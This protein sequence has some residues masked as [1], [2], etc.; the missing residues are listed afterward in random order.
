[1]LGR[2]TCLGGVSESTTATAVGL[3]RPR[4]AGRIGAVHGGRSPHAPMWH[5]AAVLDYAF[6]GGIVSG[7]AI[8]A[9]WTGLWLVLALAGRCASRV[10]GE[11]LPFLPAAWLGMGLFLIYVLAAHLFLPATA[12][13]WWPFA[14]AAAVELGLSRRS[15]WRGVTGA[16]ATLRPPRTQALA[17]VVVMTVLWLA[18]SAIGPIINYD[19]GLYHLQA[20]QWAHDYPAVP[21]LANL[22]HRFGFTSAWF[23]YVS[24]LGVGP[25]HG[26]TSHIA[27]GSVLGL[28]M[29][30]QWNCLARL[31]FDRVPRP[32]LILGT[33]LLPVSFHQV[34]LGL[35]ASPSYDQ[36]AYSFVVGSSLYALRA[37]SGTHGLLPVAL[38]TAGAAA[39]IRP[40]FAPFATVLIA[41]LLLS[42]VRHGL[43]RGRVALLCGTLGVGAASYLASNVI[44]SGYPLYPLTVLP[45]P[46]DWRM[47]AATAALARPEILHYARLIG[48]GVTDGWTWL[49]QWTG[50][51][52]SEWRY[53]SI[54]LVLG[55]G[56]ALLA[57]G[58]L[59]RRGGRLLPVARAWPLLVLLSASTLNAVWWFREAPD[60]RLGLGVLWTLA[61]GTFA[62]GVLALPARRL[63]LAL[64][65]MAVA[66]LAIP[67]ISELNQRTL[68]SVWPATLLEGRLDLVGPRKPLTR[69][70]EEGGTRYAV[71]VRGDQCHGAPKPCAAFPVPGLRQRGESLGDGYRVIETGCATSLRQEKGAARVHHVNGSRTPAAFRQSDTPR[72]SSSSSAPTHSPAEC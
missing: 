27:T 54:V 12:A 7:A 49:D 37:L 42:A 41:V 67:A 6:L 52:L 33:V 62:A 72:T 40:Q 20:V 34:S 39:L 19:S 58:L 35:M 10:T 63:R 48:P 4:M 29:I 57:C 8:A 70:I 71:P 25:W 5:P 44:A 18:N 26:Q 1:M 46:V 47:P 31:A 55:S 60:P 9:S 66:V 53:L 69:V 28:L 36:V 14:V 17:A 45:A 13:L 51:N 23:P 3:A 65:A 38:F 64:V 68:F 43:S 32:D 50:R 21:G 22:H 61:A 15:I 16:R 11:P 24:T 2:R 59:A 30:E 56:L